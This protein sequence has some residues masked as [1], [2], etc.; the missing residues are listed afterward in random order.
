VLCFRFLDDE[1]NRRLLSLLK[2]KQVEHSVDKAGCIRYSETDEELMDG[3]IGT[4]RANV[5]PHWQ[6]LTCPEEWV[7]VYK[8]YM[9]DHG[10]PFRV[11]WTGDELWFLIPRKYRPH[12]WKLEEPGAQKAKVKSAPGRSVR[13]GRL[14][15]WPA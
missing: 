3:L 14:T 7:E 12:V 5:F 13:N 15:K 8:R 10:I 9:T 1:L 6:V 11:E 4:I 2:G